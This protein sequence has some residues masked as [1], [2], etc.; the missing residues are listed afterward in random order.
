[1]DKKFEVLWTD[2]VERS[3]EIVAANKDEALA[4]W[5]RGDYDTDDICEND[6]DLISEEHEI[7]VNE[8]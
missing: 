4:K 5:K 6:C 2:R 1:M 8:A 7:E 3:V